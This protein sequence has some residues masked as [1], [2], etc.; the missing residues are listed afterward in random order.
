MW[1]LH[2]ID[3]SQIWQHVKAEP[4]RTKA[5]PKVWRA[6]LQSAPITP[7]L[8]YDTVKPCKPFRCSFSFCI[9]MPVVECA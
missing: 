8:R 6:A 4:W 3:I 7:S 2:S 9:V 5:Q 1:Q